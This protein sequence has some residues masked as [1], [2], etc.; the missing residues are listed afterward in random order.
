M[1]DAARA[2]QK[3]HLGPPYEAAVSL[4][5]RIHDRFGMTKALAKKFPFPGPWAMAWTDN[6]HFRP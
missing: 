2:T 3:G 4:G 6:V 1:R 5:W